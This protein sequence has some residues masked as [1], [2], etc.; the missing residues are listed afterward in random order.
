MVDSY[1]DNL[2]I[3]NIFPVVCIYF[4][5]K[6][7]VHNVNNVTRNLSLQTHFEVHPKLVEMFSFDQRKKNFQIVKRARRN[8]VSYVCTLVNPR[9]NLEKTGKR[10]D[11]N[12]K[13]KNGQR[14][15]DKSL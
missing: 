8:C 5:S 13:K 2:F 12:S 4:A 7:Y 6:V 11:E 10:I 15:E 14:I 3:I 9:S 1:T